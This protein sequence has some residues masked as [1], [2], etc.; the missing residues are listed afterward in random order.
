MSDFYIFK[1]LFNSFWIGVAKFEVKRSL[2]FLGIKLIVFTL[3]ILG[4]KSISLS[5][6]STKKVLI[7]LISGHDKP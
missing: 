4:N 5:L 6:K 2:S 1:I 7:F 3:P